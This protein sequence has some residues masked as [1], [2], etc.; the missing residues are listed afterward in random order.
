MKKNLN[1]IF[2]ES[3]PQELDILTDSLNAA[4]LPDEVL[5]SIKGK[6]YAKSGLKK[7]KKSK[8]SLWLR[9]GLIAACIALVLSV[10]A[11]AMLLRENE[12]K[13]TSS[14][15]DGELFPLIDFPIRDA[16][17]SANEV[18]SIFDNAIDG[19]NGTNQY[20]EIYTSDP[21]HLNIASL[22]TTE[23]LPIYYS[24]KSAASKKELQKFIDKYLDLS[25]SFFGISSKSY[26]IQEYE[27]WQGEDCYI[28][29][30]R[31]EKAG[32]NFSSANNKLSFS[33]YNLGE[34]RLNINGS[35]IS[36]MESDSDKQIKKKLSDTV[37][38]LNEF[39]GKNYS[40][41]KIHRI[42]SDKQLRTIEVY[43][44]SSEQTIFSESFSNAPMTSDY[45][46]LK[47]CTDWGEGTIRN[48]GGSKEEAFLTDFSL[49][50]TLQDW[51]NYYNG[52]VNVKMLTLQKAE[53]LLEKGYVFGGHSCPLCMAEQPE[54]D[55]GEYDYVDIEY[56]FSPNRKISIPFYAF[57]KYIGESDNGFKIYAKTYVAAIEVSGYEEYFKVQKN[58]HNNN[59]YYEEAIS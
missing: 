58:N 57:Y 29:E 59:Y 23:Y 21:K 2:D 32:I 4:E 54:V 49:Y 43:L 44:Y 46:C 24:N 13:I 17:L 33:N 25:T 50:E 8:K 31:G 47:F 37:S 45:I 35:M 40:Y 20:T 48:W 26:K 7:A 9:F 22:P 6:V 27:V 14:G 53:E 42:Y 52:T 51:K 16:S 10:I 15:S 36:I 28:A 41:I 3:K 56:V 18:A 30:I 39:F 5:D 34:K 19:V 12:L 38:Y 55:F 1:E 11:V